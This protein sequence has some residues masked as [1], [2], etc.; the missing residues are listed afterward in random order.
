M[1]V[2]VDDDLI[3][4]LTKD[5]ASRELS[6]APRRHERSDRPVAPGRVRL[7]DLAGLTP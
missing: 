3:I 4:W 7:G 5:L 1:L 6:T 2:T